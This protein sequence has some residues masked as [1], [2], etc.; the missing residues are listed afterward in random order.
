[1]AA[2]ADDDMSD[3][4]GRRHGDGGLYRFAV[5]VAPVSADH[6]GAGTPLRHVVENRLQE[7]FEVVRLLE[8]GDA[9]AQ[10]GG[11][12]LLVV[13]GA[14]GDFADGHRTGFGP[15]GVKRGAYLIVPAWHR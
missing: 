15:Y 4:V 1:M 3:P 8:Y 2:L 11:A 6:H 14:G 9:F 13:V 5:E 12:G 7:V 10:A